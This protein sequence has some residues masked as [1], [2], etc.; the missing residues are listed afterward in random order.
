MPPIGQ[1]L[2]FR[3][4]IFLDWQSNYIHRPRLVSNFIIGGSIV[5][6]D[7]VESWPS[8]RRK[9][10]STKTSYLGFQNHVIFL[11]FNQV[12]HERKCSRED[13]REEESESIE[14]HVSLGEE[15]SRAEVGA[16]LKIGSMMRRSMIRFLFGLV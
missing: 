1:P 2:P 4:E 5:H 15:L 7:R 12:L 8:R 9:A 16:S 3:L 6:R 11:R 10:R 13:E 14:V